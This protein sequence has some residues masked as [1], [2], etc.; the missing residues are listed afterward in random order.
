VLRGSS[1][2]LTASDC[3]RLTPLVIAGRMQSAALGA[4]ETDAE[5]LADRFTTQ[6]EHTASEAT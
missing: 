4:W 1:C 3:V 5:E 2:L 6:T